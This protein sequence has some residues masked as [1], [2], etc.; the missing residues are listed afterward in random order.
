MLEKNIDDFPKYTIREDGCVFNE[1]GYQ[2]QP[3]ILKGYHRVTLYNK[4]VRRKV[5]IHRLVAEH[6]L[7][8]MTGKDFVNHID[9][10]RN[11]NNVRNLEWVTRKENIQHS[12]YKWCKPFSVI[13]GEGV[14]HEGINLTE[15]CKQQRLSQ[16]RMSDV[17][18]GKQKSHKGYKKNAE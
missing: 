10:V 16:S 9:E 4:R 14:L 18:L 7:E 11:N 17:V 1:H 13:D 6:F 2:L 8:K 5:F 12:L 15:F 3:E